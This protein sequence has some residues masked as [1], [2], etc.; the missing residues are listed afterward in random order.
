MEKKLSITFFKTKSFE[1]KHSNFCSVGTEWQEQRRFS[2]KSLKDLGFGKSSMESLIHLEVN[3]LNDCLF[4][5]VGKTIDLKN[6][7]NISVINALWTLIS[8]RRYE[9][10]HPDLL[11][12]VMKVDRLT[13]TSQS[14]I[15][16][17]FP[18]LVK[19]APGLTGF[20]KTSK[21]ILDVIGFVQNTITDHVQEFEVSGESK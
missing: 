10:N 3:A 19:I 2:L 12:I 13:N 11:D 14:S 21:L 6:R 4:K 20:S 16:S 5:D 18:W 8:G 1:T 9:L 17:L 7:F 15:S